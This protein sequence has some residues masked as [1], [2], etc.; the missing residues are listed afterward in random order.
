MI[1]DTSRPDLLP[2]ARRLLIIES[3]AL[4]AML[5]VSAWGWMRIPASTPIAVHWGAAGQPNQF[6]G[7]AVGLF[8]MP[9]LAFAVSLLMLA[10]LMIPKL[11][12]VRSMKAYIAVATSVLALLLSL[13]VITVLAAAGQ[14]MNMPLIV[15][16]L[17][18]AMFIVIGN[19]FPKMRRNR[20]MG[21]RTPWTRA[22]EYCWDKTHRFAAWM[23]IGLGLALIVLAWS[24][25]N[26]IITSG[27]VL[28]GI[29]AVTLVVYIYSY[30]VF[31]TNPD[32]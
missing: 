17:V 13:H 25:L 22:S 7:K 8:W 20:W 30:V 11:E 29:L 5:A 23:F 9:G 21:V 26:I 24:S 16:T 27:L 32:K 28:F 3:V 1:E 4:L 6:V 31:I 10:F 15:L 18:G 2:A 19:Y 14:R 12:A